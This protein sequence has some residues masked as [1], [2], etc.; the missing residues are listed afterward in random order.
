MF[1]WSFMVGAYWITSFAATG[2][3]KRIATALATIYTVQ[4][5]IFDLVFHV[6]GYI[7]YP[8]CMLADMF[9]FLYV[10]QFKN[11]SHILKSYDSL[12]LLSAILNFVGYGIYMAELPN[13]VYDLPIVVLHA[14]IMYLLLRRESHNGSRGC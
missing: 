1:T 13:F 3:R 14:Y 12:L 6:N 5:F 2:D 4:H 9:C 11:N 8:T 10:I 7:Y